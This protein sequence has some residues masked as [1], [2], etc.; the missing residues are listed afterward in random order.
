MGENGDEDFDCSGFRLTAALRST[1]MNPLRFSFGRVWL[2]AQNTFREAVRQRLFN[3]IALLAVALVLGAQWFRDLDFGSSELKFIADFGFGAMAFFGAALTI[4][5]SAQLFFSEIEQR[6]VLTLLSKPMRRSE[7][8]VGKFIGV[9]LV[10]ASFCVALTVL[11]AAVL[12]SRE[13]ALMRSFPDVF[14]HGRAIDYAAVLIAGFAQWL[15][16]AILSALT[17]LIAT[18]VRTQLFA[19]TA[20]FLIL[21]ICHLSFLA[22]RSAQR[23]DSTGGRWVAELI[24]RSV[25]D[26]RLFDL[27]ESVG[28]SDVVGWGQLVR[29]TVYTIC[30]GAAICSLAAFVFRRREI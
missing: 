14:D 26:F 13:T 20:G 11:L 29:L 27:S 23:A 15:K 7:F 24:S 19:T 8:V 16:L 3:F 25:P 6:T 22:D 21:V 10:T 30:Y 1:S 18:L 17:L 5:A 9:S 28:S 2:I 4:L 12:W